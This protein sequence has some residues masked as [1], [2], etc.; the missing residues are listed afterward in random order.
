MCPET[1]LPHQRN[2]DSKQQI[3]LKSGFFVH[4]GPMNNTEGMSKFMQRLAQ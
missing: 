4:P 3:P 2:I 1:D